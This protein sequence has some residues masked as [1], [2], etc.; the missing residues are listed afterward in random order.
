MFPNPR[1][2]K[3]PKAQEQN[4]RLEFKI[5]SPHSKGLRKLVWEA[6]THPL[7]YPSPG[8]CSLRPGVASPILDLSKIGSVYEG[9]TWVSM[10]L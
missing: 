9:R 10:L 3:S 7:P 5:V 4:Q 1:L 2:R 8:L 6:L